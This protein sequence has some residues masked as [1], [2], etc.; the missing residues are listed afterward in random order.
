MEY[1]LMKI[2]L[3]LVKFIDYHYI[4]LYFRVIFK[5]LFDKKKTLIFLQFAT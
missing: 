2:I 5:I 1:H 4:F 3:Y